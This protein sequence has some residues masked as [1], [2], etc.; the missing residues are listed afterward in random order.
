MPFPMS[1]ARSLADTTYT[2]ASVMFLYLFLFNRFIKYLFFNHL[3]LWVEVLDLTKSFS[4][5]QA[6][7]LKSHTLYIHNFAMS[8]PIHMVRK[9][10]NKNEGQIHWNIDR[11]ISKSIKNTRCRFSARYTLFCSKSDD[12]TKNDKTAHQFS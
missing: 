10:C 2:N 1:P 5:S 12:N 7:L 3:F 4:L 11:K 9:S 6:L 8:L